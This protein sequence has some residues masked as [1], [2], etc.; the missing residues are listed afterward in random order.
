MRLIAR[1]CIFLS[2]QVELVIFHLVFVKGVEGDPGRNF[3]FGDSG[4]KFS[5]LSRAFYGISPILRICRG[6]W[7]RQGVILGHLEKFDVQRVKKV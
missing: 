6:R 7:G 1:F 5:V 3:F 2:I 4:R